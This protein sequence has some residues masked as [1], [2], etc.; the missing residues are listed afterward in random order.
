MVTQMAGDEAWKLFQRTH[1]QH[2]RTVFLSDSRGDNFLVPV[3]IAGSVNR[4]SSI[5]CDFSLFTDF[6]K[7]VERYQTNHFNII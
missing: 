2:K 1:F 7:H 3:G 6:F 5:C 4:I